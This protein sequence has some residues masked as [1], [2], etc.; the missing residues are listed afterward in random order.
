MKRCAACEADLEHVAACQGNTGG[1]SVGVSLT[2]DEADNTIARK[3]SDIVNQ[4]QPGAD[5]GC[6]KVAAHRLLL[7]LGDHASR[8]EQKL[9][10]QIAVLHAECAMLTELAAAA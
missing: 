4:C 9:A 3:P 5:S 2:S 7:G 1:V 6:I 8:K 10:V